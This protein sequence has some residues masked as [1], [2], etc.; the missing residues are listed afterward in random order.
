MSYLPEYLHLLHFDK[1]LHRVHAWSIVLNQPVQLKTTEAYFIYVIRGVCEIYSVEW[2]WPPNWAGQHSSTLLW[3][4]LLSKWQT[5]WQSQVGEI[6]HGG[7]PSSKWHWAPPPCRS[8]ADRSQTNGSLSSAMFSPP[9]HSSLRV[10]SCFSSVG[11]WRSLSRSLCSFGCTTLISV[12]LNNVSNCKPWH[13]HPLAFW[14]EQLHCYSSTSEEHKSYIFLILNTI[15]DLS[16]VEAFRF[17]L[18]IISSMHCFSHFAAFAQTGVG[19]ELLLLL[20]VLLCGPLWF[21]LF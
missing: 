11:S 14:L 19:F 3:P 12:S 16:N 1:C 7:P 8:A 15:L 10:H 13:L 18:I 21:H 5:V 20:C 6:Y 2:K 4:Q 9:L 17:N